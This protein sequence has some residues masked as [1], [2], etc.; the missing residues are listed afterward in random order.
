MLRILMRDG[1]FDIV[2]STVLNQ[3]ISAREVFAFFRPVN[4]KWCII[5]HG[6]VRT[7]GRPDTYFGIERRR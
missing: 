5:G 2:N 7:V 6:I 1:K 4:K 3:L